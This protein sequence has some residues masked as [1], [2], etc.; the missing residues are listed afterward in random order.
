MFELYGKEVL[1]LKNSVTSS[2]SDRELKTLFI[3]WQKGLNSPL[4]SSCG[5]LFDSVASILGIIQVC[6]YEGESGLLLESLYDDNIEEYYQ[7]FIDEGKIDFSEIV[8]QI[9]QEKDKSYL[10]AEVL[11]NVK[12]Y[13][14]RVATTLA[15]VRYAEL[16]HL[17]FIMGEFEPVQRKAEV[18]NGK[19]YEVLIFKNSVFPASVGSLELGPAKISANIVEKERSVI[20]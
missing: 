6:S 12:L 13:V 16:E 2:F 10:N 20:Q 15:D 17:G 4:S 3:A 19:N 1:T 14:D 5:R 11:V 9:L 7:F 8:K 18:L